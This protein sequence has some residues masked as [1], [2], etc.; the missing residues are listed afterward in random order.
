M[1]P[2]CQ[3]PGCGSWWGL[4][5]FWMATLWQCMRSHGKEY[6]AYERQTLTMWGWDWQSVHEASVSDK[7]WSCEASVTDKLWSC[8]AS[9]TDKVWS[10]EASVTN[11]GHVRL[12]WQTN[13]SCEA[14]VTDKLWSCE[15]S[16][17]DS[18]HVWLLWQTNSGHVR[19]QWQTNYGHVRLWLESLKAILTDPATAI[20]NAPFNVTLQGKMAKPWR[21]WNKFVSESSPWVMVGCQNPLYSLGSK[22]TFIIKLNVRIP[23]GQCY[24][25]GSCQNQWGIEISFARTPRVV[26]TVKSHNF[27]WN[28]S[29]F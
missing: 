18:G 14:S 2:A 7:L 8:V 10:C 1:T 12:L 13:W 17:T 23:Q 20:R 6:W 3:P 21:F 26:L 9:M 25:I 29:H 11:Y 28:E 24:S 19:L 15:A 5:R 16:V 4:V 27:V 22:P